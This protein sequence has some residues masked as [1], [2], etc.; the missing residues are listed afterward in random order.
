MS[1][2][3]TGK[4]A[5]ENQRDRKSKEPSRQTTRHKKGIEKQR[6]KRFELFVWRV[7]RH[8]DAAFDASCAKHQTGRANLV[9]AGTWCPG[10]G[11]LTTLVIRFL[12]RGIGAEDEEAPETAVV[13][14]K[15]S[16]LVDI[17]RLSSDKSHESEQPTLPNKH[18]G[19]FGGWQN[20]NRK[21]A[22]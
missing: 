15:M 20:V 9:F 16:R 8:R 18:T 7:N 3:D 5:S 1:V 19:S 17:S 14:D 10:C 21:R 22:N 4:S 12:R 2:C 6:A 13:S 11:R